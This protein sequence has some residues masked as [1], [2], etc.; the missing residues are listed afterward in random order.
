MI[1]CAMLLCLALMAC[2]AC[3][4]TASA[5]DKP[6]VY[7]DELSCGE[8]RY[9]MVTTWLANPLTGDLE[10]V[11][12]SLA[13]TND[14]RRISTQLPLGVRPV[15]HMLV[16]GHRVLDDRVTAWACIVSESGQHYLFLLYSCRP[17]SRNCPADSAAEWN[18]I[19][20]TIGHL[21]TGAR[22]GMSEAV[23]RRLGIE[24]A[25]RTLT[26]AGVGPNGD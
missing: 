20:D 11:G 3:W 4:Q 25:L 15:P 23:L 16:R 17:A 13:L 12:Q 22:N 1:R 24:K 18:Q 6:T 5:G 2:A 7:Q 19:L 10:Y 9:R 8:A 26:T 21:I 14:L